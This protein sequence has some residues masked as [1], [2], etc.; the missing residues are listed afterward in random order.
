[1]DKMID[2]EAFLIEKLKNKK[3]AQAYL[4]AA[5]EDFIEDHDKA[6]FLQAL[7]AIALAQGGIAKLSERTSLN[8]QNLYRA[9]SSKGNPK[10][11]TI[12]SIIKGL[13]FKMTVIITSNIKK[14]A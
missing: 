7:H 6:S 2:Y 8:R 9:L 4:D 5:L 12:G 14:R 10:I 1:M 3:Q 13:G 11:D